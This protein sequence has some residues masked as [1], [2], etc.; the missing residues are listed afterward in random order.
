V[1]IPDPNKYKNKDKYVEA[2]MSA[3]GDEYDDS[4]QALAVCFS[5]WKEKKSMSEN[6]ERRIYPFTD[7]EVRRVGGK[8]P[9]LV[10]Y[11]AVFDSL[12]DDLGGFREKI[13]P[14]TFKKTIRR[15]DVRALWNH[16][17]NY[18]L[19]RKKAKTLKLKEDEHGLRMEV[20]PPD[21][22]WANDLMVSIERGD[23]DQMSFGFLTVLD[24]WENKGKKTIRTL[25]EVE[26]IDVSPVTYPAYPDTTI[27]LRSLDEYRA[28]IEAEETS[29]EPS[30]ETIEEEQEL[31]EEETLEVTALAKAN[32]LK[33]RQ[34]ELEGNKNES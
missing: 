31:E 24:E 23:V 32:Y 10:G 30:D 5:K 4:D 14:G 12:S 9:K 34:R 18:V 7:I 11:A 33:L 29:P 3:I 28:S 13:S 16:D 22:Q 1:P 17:P 15:S 25:K 8:P 20:E 27:A 6:I 26:L 2:C 21:T 19:G